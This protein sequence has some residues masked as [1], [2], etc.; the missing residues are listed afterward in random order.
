[1]F[2]SRCGAEVPRHV[3]FCG[4]CGQTVSVAEPAG[5]AAS[6]AAPAETLTRDSQSNSTMLLVVGGCVVG[7]FIGFLMRPSAFLI[8]QLPLGTV[9]TRGSMLSGLDM[10]LVPTAQASFNV[11]AIGLTVG[12]VLGGIVSYLRTNRN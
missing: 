9:I 8:G 1:M 3:K 12:A 7:G 6:S 11:M 5:T 4:Q 2:C 10:L